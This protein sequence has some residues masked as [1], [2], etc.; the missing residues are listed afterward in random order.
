MHGRFWA[1][2]KD[3]VWMEAQ[4][5]LSAMNISGLDL[6]PNDRKGRPGFMSAANGTPASMR[7][8][9][10]SCSP[11]LRRTV[12]LSSTHCYIAKHHR[13]NATM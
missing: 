1:A 2:T 8:N 4:G 9:I 10:S 7:G 5:A 11:R 3:E 12:M 13:S 6:L